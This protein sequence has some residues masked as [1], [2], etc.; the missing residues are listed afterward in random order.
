ML[1]Y[2]LPQGPRRMTAF[3]VV[4]ASFSAL[5]AFVATVFVMGM[6]I[7]QSLEGIE[8]WWALIPIFGTWAVP[9]GIAI[10]AFR[11]SYYS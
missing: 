5:F 11:R 1:D 9:T 8:G 3:R 2:H 10:I 6:C 7:G 4:A